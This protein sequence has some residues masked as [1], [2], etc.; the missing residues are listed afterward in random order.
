MR[1]QIV[2]KNLNSLEPGLCNGPQFRVE[3]AT[4]RYSSD[5]VQHSE[6]SSGISDAGGTTGLRRACTA[7]LITVNGPLRWVPGIAKQL[8]LSLCNS[9]RRLPVASGFLRLHQHSK[10]SED[11]RPN[12]SHELARGVS[13]GQMQYYALGHLRIRMGA[14]E[15]IRRGN[16]GA[17]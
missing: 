10:S 12:D 11:V 9:Y 14:T 2:L 13:D 1:Q 3:R 5:G 8:N 17:A 4:H 15:P 6:P 7:L 16:V